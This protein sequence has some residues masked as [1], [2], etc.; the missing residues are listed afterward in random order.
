MVGELQQVGADVHLAEPAET[1][2]LKGKRRAKTD[3]AD[4]QHLRELLLIGSLRVVDRAAHILNLRA[5]VRCR[6]TLLHQRT[7]WQQRMQAVLY[8][9]RCPQTRKLL[10]LAKRDWIAGL[11][12]RGRPGGSIALEMID[13]IEISSAP[14]SCAA[15]LCPPKQEPGAGR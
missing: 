8:H 7:E 14:G 12:L 3:W 9:H 4:A 6:H 13:A 1:S 2:N 15:R 11:K 10:T 5:R